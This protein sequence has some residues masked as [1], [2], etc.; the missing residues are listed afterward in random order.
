MPLCQL[1]CP[2]THW[3]ENSIL[4]L[5]GFTLYSDA[6]HPFLNSFSVNDLHTSVAISLM[7]CFFLINFY[8]FNLKN[9]II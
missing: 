6:H 5:L 2:L 7:D 9:L 8:M 3:V 1:F 4:L